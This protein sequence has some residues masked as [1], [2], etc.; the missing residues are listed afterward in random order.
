SSSGAGCE[1]VLMRFN[2]ERVEGAW[3]GT[4]GLHYGDGVFRT[5]LVRGGRLMQRERQLA[6]L[7]LDASRLDLEV[8]PELGD[9]VDEVCREAG[10]GALR[11]VLSRADSG[12]G[13]VPRGSRCDRLVRVSPLPDHAPESWRDGIACAWSPVLLAVQPRLAG[14][15]H[16]NR[17]EQVLASRDWPAT[18]QEVLMCDAEGRV[19]AGSRSNVFFVIEGV[20]V[21][22][23]LSFAG[24]AGMMRDYLIE[25]G[26]Q[27]GMACEIGLISPD[28]VRHATEGFACNS[29]IGIWPLRSVGSVAFESPGPITR[30]MIDLL[31]HPWSGTA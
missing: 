23:D 17:L 28:E 26:R 31:R 9:E 21:T 12:R 22:P 15:K 2:G 10:E 29:L 25:L 20:L 19:T 3:T 30:R 8:A 24:V 7:T 4:R 27:A 1:D 18:C 16:L 5:G 14:I 13:Y 11:I 6:R